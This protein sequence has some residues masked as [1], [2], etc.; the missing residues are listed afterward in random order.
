MWSCKVL[1]FWVLLCAIPFLGMSRD[2]RQA[3]VLLARA[4]DMAPDSAQLILEFIVGLRIVL[5]N[6]EQSVADM[7]VNPEPSNRLAVRWS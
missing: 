3:R 2:L 1:L 5:R 7:M 6:C 4:C